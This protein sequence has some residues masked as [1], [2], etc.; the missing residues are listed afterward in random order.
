MA[1]KKQKLEDIVT[2][3][4]EALG[5]VSYADYFTQT[6]LFTNLRIENGGSE[7]LADLTLTV[8]NDHGLLVSCVRPIE[9]VP[10][11]ARWKWTSATS[12]PPFISWGWKR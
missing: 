3:V 6:P 10:L 2:L 4:A 11:K 12:F 1:Q 8:S 7:A 5:V 9:E